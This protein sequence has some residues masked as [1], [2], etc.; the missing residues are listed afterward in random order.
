MTNQSTT[1]RGPLF[2]II[3][4]S[5]MCH[6]P[7]PGFKSDALLFQTIRL[8][9]SWHWVSTE[10]H[11]MIMSSTLFLFGSVMKTY[12]IVLLVLLPPPPTGISWLLWIICYSSQNDTP[13]REHSLPYIRRRSQLSR[14]TSSMIKHFQLPFDFANS[15][16]NSP[17]ITRSFPCSSPLFA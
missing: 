12:S 16:F 13:M 11:P 10:L 9:L 5:P 8:T 7:S 6:S 17:I 4:P 2:P 3:V 14:R 1:V 15:C